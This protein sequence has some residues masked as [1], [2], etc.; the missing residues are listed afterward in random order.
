[1]NQL[2]P[3][4][5]LLLAAAIW[6]G[7]FPLVKDA[8]HDIGPFE[9]LALRF[10]IATV[11]YVVLWPRLARKAMTVNVKAGLVVGALLAAGHGFQ[12]A[13]IEFTRATNAGF[14]TGLYVVFTPILAAAFLKRRPS[15]IVMFGVVL[16][17]VGLALMSVR[18]GDSGTAVNVGDML[19]LC[20]AIAYAG[21]IVAVGRWAP[22]MDARVLTLQQFAVTFVVFAL[23][24]PVEDMRA[25][26]TSA[27]WIALIATAFG[28]SVYGI[29]VQVWAQQRI[30]P[31]PAAIIY[32]ME[33]PF[34]AI[35][36]YFLSDERLPTRAWLGAG[37][38]LAGMLIVEF[39]LMGAARKHDRTA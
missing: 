9:F 35:A 7:T 30:S 37:L 36:A 28:S 21:Q 27:V 39:R 17:T 13:G 24:T 14:I 8:L 15:V 20:C 1:L 29:G 10:G 33:A 23:I 31:T 22:E 16:T 19:V 34:A 26:T 3:A 6:G 32:S 11:A 5:A 4:A 2:G 38:I 25:P 12:T 18:F